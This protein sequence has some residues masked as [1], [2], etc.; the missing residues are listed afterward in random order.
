V[1]RTLRFKLAAVALGIVVGAAAPSAAQR[2]AP[3]RPAATHAYSFAFQDADLGQVLD[4][5]LVR[6]LGV[7]Y[8]LDA[9]GSSKLSFRV[10]QRMTAAE[11]L[12]AL[13]ASLGS[14]DI[15]FVRD[16]ETLVVTSRAKAKSMS[17]LVAVGPGTNGGYQKRSISLVSA[18][19]SEVTKGL[20][21]M[22]MGALVITADDKINA[23]VLGGTT[24]ELQAA[25][26]AIKLFDRSPAITGRNRFVEL[27]FVGADQLA[28]ELGPV[29]TA[30][31]V[32]GVQ[33][34][35]LSRLNAVLLFGRTDQ[36]LDDAGRWIS[37]LDAQAARGQCNLWVYKPKFVS[38]DAL[39]ET[40][41]EVL[42]SSSAQ[43]SVDQR[44]SGSSPTTGFATGGTTSAPSTP[45]TATPRQ[46]LNP[47][48]NPNLGSS[49]ARVSV[50]RD[51]NSL[52]IFAPKSMRADLERLLADIDVLP[53][54]VLIEASILEVS[55]TDEFR[56][57]VNWSVLTDHGRIQII[58]T[59]AQNGT[60]APALPGAAITYIDNNIEAAIDALR[61]KTNV[62]VVSAPKL[63]ALDNRVA[64][65]QIGDQ[66][67]IAVQTAQSN[68]AADAPRLVSIDYRNT[69]VI[70]EV[71]PRI[72]GE[73]GVTLN[74]AQEVSAVS[75]TTTSGIDSPTIQ[76][77][78]FDSTLLLKSG[79]TV[80]LGGLISSSAETGSTGIPILSNIPVVGQ[81]FRSQTHDQH[82]TEL[83]V[84]L[85]AKILSDQ[86]SADDA[87]KRI[88][89]QMRG[90]DANGIKQ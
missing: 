44:G 82:R 89:S 50:D 34:T 57:G 4:E 15:V 9:S 7:R 27:K 14:Q 51:S 20:Q 79:G 37:R 85:T 59:N 41:N 71:T 65:L 68:A 87:A 10:D 24:K 53:R 72:T 58:Q 36:V 33:I 21:S 64:R 88:S 63:V 26:D 42:G 18:A 2:A 25:E 30:A 1:T 76:Q 39:C 40:L 62:R 61:S 84:L 78:R 80:A 75:R 60:V 67:P 56:M 46:P 47:S 19:P 35:P 6:T 66:V 49:D 55:L 3:A 17:P 74:V 13:E 31:G 22:G 5:V 52:V 29:L 32:T 11:L 8:R 48:Q 45:R 83:I 23:L 16:G 69:G 81:L 28:S 90:I 70:L 54:Q 38:A 73:D 12:E 43:P 77:R 86:N